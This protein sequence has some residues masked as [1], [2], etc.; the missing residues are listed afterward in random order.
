METKARLPAAVR[1][2]FE[3]RR[4]LPEQQLVMELTLGQNAENLYVRKLILSER[5]WIQ[6]QNIK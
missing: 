3:E 2:E 6:R 5:F 1:E 4:L